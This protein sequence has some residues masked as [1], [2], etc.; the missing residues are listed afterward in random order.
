MLKIFTV[1]FLKVLEELKRWDLRL[2]NELVKIPARVLVP[3]IISFG[4]KRVFMTKADTVDW[5]NAFR[6]KLFE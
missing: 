6:G 4:N 2:S 5:T 3:E 1:Y